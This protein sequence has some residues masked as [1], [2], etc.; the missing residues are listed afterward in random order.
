[1]VVDDGRDG[2][3]VAPCAEAPLPIL[4]KDDAADV[5]PGRAPK[6]AV[7]FEAR[8]ARHRTGHFRVGTPIGAPCA[9]RRKSAQR[10]HRK[11]ANLLDLHR[12]PA[13][14]ISRRRR[15]AAGPGTCDAT[16][17][18]IGEL[19]FSN[20]ECHCVSAIVKCTVLR[21]DSATEWNEGTL[22]DEELQSDAR[23]R[24]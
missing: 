13:G 4:R 18:H 9:S 23:L 6:R 24:K 14:R 21:R 20:S 11:G 1:M 17:V 22:L 16:L 7:T 12:C 8:I 5:R 3:P 10:L 15:T 19:K 2:S